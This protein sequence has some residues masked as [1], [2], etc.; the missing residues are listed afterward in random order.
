MT[1]CK[2]VVLTVPAVLL[3]AC[4]PAATPIPPDSGTGGATAD[5]GGSEVAS[6]APEPPDVDSGTE[7]D[8]V[9][10][11]EAGADSA[12]STVLRMPWTLVVLPDTQYYSASYPDRF[13]AQTNWIVNQATARNILYVVHEGDIVDND[14]D[15]QWQ[16]ASHSMHL[17]DGNVPYV[18]T[19]GNHDYPGAGGATSRDTSLFDSY[20][21]LANLQAIQPGFKGTYDPASASNSYHL[22]DAEGQTWLIISLEFGPRDAV[23][24]WAD[25]I[26]KANV[27]ANAIIVTHAYLYSDGTRYDYATRTDQAFNPHTYG[28]E[29][30]PGGVN[31]GEQIWQKLIV[32]NPNVRLV[33]CGHVH[34]EAH[35]TSTRDAGPPVHQMLADYQDV[36]Q[37]PDPTGNGDGFLRILTFQPNGAIN[38]SSY[39]PYFNEFFPEAEAV[40]ADAD[41][42][43]TLQL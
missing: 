30:L 19:I 27:S 8:A 9:L 7:A 25:G 22:F 33:L 34:A 23:L 40:P 42:T 38:V 6:D 29:Q 36:S 41:N 16:N 32:N 3:L 39:S 14:V 18:L 26:L 13:D 35:L 2:T 43:F 15:D 11:G 1:N 20:F 17:L 5:A 10:T 4:G 37:P 12:P 31:D 28:V 21:P 24:T